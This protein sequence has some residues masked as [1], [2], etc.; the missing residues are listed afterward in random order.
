MNSPFFPFSKKKS[1]IYF[2]NYAN[3]SALI[4]SAIE[5]P[6]EQSHRDYHLQ[7]IRNIEASFFRN[8]FFCHFATSKVKERS[9]KF[10]IIQFEFLLRGLRRFE[11]HPS[12]FSIRILYYRS[13]VQF[14]QCDLVDLQF[15]I[16][17]FPLSP[18]SF[19]FFFWFSFFSYFSRN[20][21]FEIRVM[22]LNCRAKMSQENSPLFL[23]FFD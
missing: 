11:I 8:L 21:G 18:T 2:E 1:K 7:E 23:H 12:Q 19:P 14:S 13:R 4:F 22:R 17:P 9:C 6:Y 10:C 5:R 20:S 3:F 15:F 16:G